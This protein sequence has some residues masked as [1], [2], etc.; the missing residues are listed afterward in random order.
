VTE[1]R[2]EILLQALTTSPTPVTVGRLALLLHSSPRT[3]RYALDELAEWLIPHG[4]R[5][6]RRPGRGIWLEGDQETLASLR[7][8][9]V[10][11]AGEPYLPAAQRRALALA[12]LLVSRSGVSPAELVSLLGVTRATVYRELDRIASWLRKRSLRLERSRGLARVLGAEVQ[13]RSGLQELL[14]EWVLETDLGP[15]GLLGAD[16][17][18]NLAPSVGVRILRELGVNDPLEL[19]GTV[20]RAAAIAA[21]PLTPGQAVGLL[22]WSAIVHARLIAGGTVEL[23]ADT[24][25][26]AAELPEYRLASELLRQLGHGPEHQEA[27]FM[28]ICARDA[29]YGPSE[30]GSF[31][32]NRV[33]N[34]ARRLATAFARQAG[35]LLGVELDQDED[36]IR[37]LMLHLEPALDRLQLGV[38][39]PNPLLEDIKAKYGGLF[40]IAK[41]ASQALGDEPGLR[42]RGLADEEIGYLA[43][44]LGAALERLA[45]PGDQTLKAVLV[46]QH[47]V[48]T[49]Q[50]LASLLASRLPELR[51]CGFASSHAVEQVASRHGADV[52][53]TTRPLAGVSLP[54]FLVNPI[55]DMIELTALRNRLYS[56]LRAPRR[57]KP[58]KPVAPSGG[59]SP[60]M[61][62]DALTEKTISLNAK[63]DNWQ[64]AI[65]RAGEL[66]VRT[67]AVKPEY[68]DGMIRGVETIGPYIV[69]GP[70]IAMP[71]ARPEDGALRV[72]LSCVRLTSPVTFPGKED[73]PVDLIFAFAGTDNTSHLTVMGQLAR[74]LSEPSLVERIR[75][76]RSVDDVLAVVHSVPPT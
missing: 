24:A 32:P 65:R 61:L 43:M 60:L 67:G 30:L 10:E 40:A 39:A 15:V 20:S 11:A 75:Q 1:R 14:L 76:A 64:E 6:V 55:P 58:G 44:H 21:Y 59:A 74:V 12:R 73:N 7:S 66:L 8:G 45:P 46:C 41:Q 17:R 57:A 5:L 52:V 62:E 22:F 18:G 51:I 29:R 2:R 72:G 35:S 3:V 4:V 47:G 27:A 37:G 23:P 68:I 26:T 50:L 19:R 63:A 42:H 36:L 16:G 28:A 38:V 48:G 9:T 54:V 56:L 53:I 49:A 70:G 13:L 71:H 34:R 31:D 69:V 33:Q 25:S